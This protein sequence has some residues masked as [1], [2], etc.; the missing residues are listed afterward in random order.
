[1]LEI[2]QNFLINMADSFGQTVTQIT[3]LD[4]VTGVAIIGVTLVLIN[5]AIQK[6][7]LE[8]LKDVY[9]VITPTVSILGFV[10]LY[11]LYYDFAHGIQTFTQQVALWTIYG[12]LGA[13]ILWGVARQIGDK[14]KG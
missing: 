12:F 5:L 9:R 13:G 14:I 3:G 7:L 1:M 8:T 4:P 6:V 11:I 10:G 2:V